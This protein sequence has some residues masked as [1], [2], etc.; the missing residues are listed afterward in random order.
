M[1]AHRVAGDLVDD[2][3]HMSRSGCL[4]A[5][6]RFRNVV[7]AVFAEVYLRQPNAADTARRLS[8]NAARWFLGMLRTMGCM[9]CERK[10]LF[11]WVAR[12][13]PY[14]RVHVHEAG[15]SQSLDLA[16]IL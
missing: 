8:I 12:P 13:V 11:I 10:K 15:V 14:E 16:R 7:V 9:Y 4:E 2:Y 5:M 6:F 3:I 1:L